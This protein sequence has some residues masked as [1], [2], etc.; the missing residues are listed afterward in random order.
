MGINIFMI[1]EPF[2]QINKH[3]VK[4]YTHNFTHLLKIKGAFLNK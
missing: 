2:N 3:T 1:F 4:I